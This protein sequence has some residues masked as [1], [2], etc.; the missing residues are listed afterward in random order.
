[1][2]LHVPQR[3]FEITGR[4]SWGSMCLTACVCR[5]VCIS[6]SSVTLHPSEEV[7]LHVNMLCIVSKAG[8]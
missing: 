3:T 4:I 5:G 7:T 2:A 8:V 6:M 1:V